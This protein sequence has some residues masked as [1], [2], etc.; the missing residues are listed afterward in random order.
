M[1]PLGLLSTIIL[2]TIVACRS[3]GP[4]TM[5]HGTRESAKSIL[6]AFL[7]ELVDHPPT[8]ACGQAQLPPK[9]RRL[10]L[11]T[12]RHCLSCRNMGLVMRRLV[13]AE[14]GGFALFVP[15]KDAAEVCSFARLERIEAP[16][17][18]IS[19]QSFPARE[20]RDKFLYGIVNKRGEITLAMLATDAHEIVADSSGDV[21]HTATGTS[22]R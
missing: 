2:T 20:L 15:S 5:A 19:D 3:P 21:A 17:F 16:I 1:R 7:P 14:R 8:L 9:P 6:A 4:S 13:S 22:P 18:A 12:A 10:L 11:V